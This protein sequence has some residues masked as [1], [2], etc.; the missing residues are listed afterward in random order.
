MPT[1]T[2][3]TRRADADVAARIATEWSHAY[4]VTGDETLIALLDRLAALSRAVADLQEAQARLDA[5]NDHT[6]ISLGALV[7]QRDTALRAALAAEGD[8]A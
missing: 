5:P 3:E 1:I 2:P 6:E 8:H 4:S 7:Q